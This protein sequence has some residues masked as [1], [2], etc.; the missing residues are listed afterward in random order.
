MEKE[1]DDNGEMDENTEKDT[2]F[3]R[4]LRKTDVVD[5]ISLSIDKKVA[6]DHLPVLGR[7]KS[8]ILRKTSSVWNLC[9]LALEITISVGEIQGSSQ[10]EIYGSLNC[11]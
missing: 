7:G 4:C 5:S 1:A 8:Q 6:E 11:L 10:V 3:C 9:T 2:V